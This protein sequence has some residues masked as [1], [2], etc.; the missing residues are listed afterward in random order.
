MN[1]KPLQA[2]QD[3]SDIHAKRLQYALGIIQQW[4]PLSVD[5]FKAVPEQQIPILELFTSRFSKLQDSMGNQ[6]FPAVLQRALEEQPNMTFV[7]VLNKMEK[8]G[9]IP[10]GK[11]WL[12]FR[13]MRNHLT[14]E[15]PDHPE[16]AANNFNQALIMAVDLLAVY[17]HLKTFIAKLSSV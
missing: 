4:G 16:I 15:Y 7:D 1:Q 9:A 10:S 8:I 11:Q 12:D 6:L 17:A 5:F 13:N 14:H 3:I 2:M